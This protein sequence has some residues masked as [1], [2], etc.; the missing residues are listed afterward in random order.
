MHGR[1][2]VRMRQVVSIGNVLKLFCVNLI[3]IAVAFSFSFIV[4]AV[5]NI[6][7]GVFICLPLIEI[8]AIVMSLNAEAYVKDL[9][10]QE[11]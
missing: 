6:V 4:L 10:A 2:K 7:V 8:A 9:A 11:E 5:A 3:I 1:K